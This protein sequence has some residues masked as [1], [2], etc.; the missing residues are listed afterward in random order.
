MAEK[1]GV[2]QLEKIVEAC[3]EVINVVHKIT[4]GGGVLSALALIDELSALKDLNGD[5]LLQEVKDL[6]PEERKQLLGVLKAKVS[7]FDV[8]LENKIESGADCLNE[9]V[10]FGMLCYADVLE[11]KAKVEARVA[12]GKA[13]V[14]KI[15]GVVG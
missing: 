2:V 14:E 8:D 3:G 6:S 7:L 10:E 13:L 15:K 9:V 1:L 11:I 12:S 5:A 4:H